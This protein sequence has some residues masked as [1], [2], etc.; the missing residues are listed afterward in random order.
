MENNKEV[1][2]NIET[3]NTGNPEEKLNTFTQEDMNNIVAKNV[4]EERTKILKELG[5]ENVDNYKKS[6]EA[7]NKYQDSQKTELQKLQD[8]SKIK[9]D[10]ILNL[11]NKLKNIENGK[12]VDK[13]LKDMSIDLIYSETIIK[14]MDKEELTD[15]INDKDLK[16]IINKTIETYLPNLKTNVEDKKKVG[17]EKPIEQ[18][19][20][21]SNKK[22]LDNKYKSNPFYKG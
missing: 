19:P 15:D 6:L 2:E 17:F 9:D 13:L 14:L 18:I 5:I 20:V 4:K 12:K 3:K 7:F 21:G 8:E 10:T 1:K 16:A 11:T 22:Y